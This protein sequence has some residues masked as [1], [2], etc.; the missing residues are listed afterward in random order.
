MNNLTR[1]SL[2]RGSAGLL[3]AGAIARPFIANAAAKTATA[4]FTQ[5]FVQAEDTALRKVVADYEKQSGNK[6]NLSIMP[7]GALRQKIIAALTSGVVPDL[8]DA[9]PTPILPEEAWKD[10]LVDVTDV[11]ET[12]KAQYSPTAWLASQAYNAVKK[13]R[14]H[15]G[16]PF[17]GAV[18][19]FH[20][21]SSLVEK[22]GYKVSDIPDR[23][24]AFL[25]FFKP[26]Q[27]KLRAKGM[28]SVYGLG[29]TVSTT[30]FAP[31]ETFD[32]FIVAYGGENL[33]GKN[34]HLHADDPRVRQAALKTMTKL[35]TLFKE[36]YIPP[37]SLNWND[38][39]DNN[40][41]HSK[42][43]VMDLDG[44]LSTEVAMLKNNKQAYYHDVIT[45]G[46]PLNDEGKPFPSFFNAFMNMIPKGAKNVAVAKEFMT[47]FIQ[48]EV[49]NEF[50]KGGLGRWLPVMPKQAMH[51]PWWTDPKID[52]HRPVYFHQGLIAP[53]QPFWFMGNPAYAEVW[54]R[55]VWD[56]DFP[57]V[58]NGAMTPKQA[59][60]R[61]FTRIEKIFTR[62][63]IEAA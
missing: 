4:W 44:T 32:H 7:F 52:P 17:K 33:V 41:F 38:A 63:P 35:T 9:E 5:G 31:P 18:D 12:Q 24:D 27:D 8:M 57:K 26:V 15:Y 60:D 29:L 6:I 45:R 37:E 20:I 49:D 34:G 59:I 46:M 43:M 11:V 42:L 47:Y 53:T 56:A 50:L 16:I 61:A 39:D 36:G 54:T 2:L 10:R 13:E 3:A 30:G 55:Q 40:D 48:P 22:A 28:R 58:V 23:W 62:Y 51:D 25:D 21:W 19:P 1:R 14:S